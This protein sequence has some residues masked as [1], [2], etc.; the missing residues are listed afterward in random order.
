MIGRVEDEVQG[1]ARHRRR[2]DGALAAG[3]AEA[4]FSDGKIKIGVLNDQSGLYADL[5][6]QGSVLAARLAIEDMGGSLDGTA[7]EVV[8]ADHQ[9]KPDVG[10]N[11]ARQ[12]YDVERST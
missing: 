1:I 4:A 8:F 10:S 6:G 3:T 11:I 2:G 5:G 7:I 9:N 12:W